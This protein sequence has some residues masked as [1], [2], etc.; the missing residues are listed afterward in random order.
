[1]EAEN[2]ALRTAMHF[3][4]ATGSIPGFVP[5]TTIPRLLSWIGW[6]ALAL[7][8]I[9]MAWMS[10][11]SATATPP[12]LGWLA[13]NVVSV[14][15]DV[16]VGLAAFLTGEASGPA[17]IVAASIRWIALIS[18]GL[19][20]FALLAGRKVNTAATL[21][22]PLTLVCGLMMAPVDSHAFELRPR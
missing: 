14:G 15:I 11:V 9:N 3:A 17:A 12:W 1:M 2:Q 8:A 22:L 4:D 19:A 13:P 18:I 21:S 7:W 6:A 20:G 5:R 16:T 10:L